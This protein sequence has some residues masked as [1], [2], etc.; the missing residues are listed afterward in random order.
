MAT[1]SSRLAVTDLGRWPDAARDRSQRIGAALTEVPLLVAFG[2]G[3]I[4]FIISVRSPLLPGYL[5]LMSGYSIAELETGRRRN[6][7]DAQGDR[8][9]RC[10]VHR[11]LRRS[12]CRGNRHRVGSPGQPG[13]CRAGGRLGGGRVRRP[14]V[15]YVALQ[16]APAVGAYPRAA[17]RC[18]PLPVGNVGTTADGRGLRVRLDPCIGPVLGAILTT[19]AVQESVGRGMLLLL[20]YGLG[21]RSSLRGSPGLP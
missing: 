4:S 3:I 21:P 10:R 13:P 2:A 16:L 20:F 6:R 12:R 15:G 7:E 17:D 5:S 19:A 18:P 8:P 11:G 9:L 14:P 1:G